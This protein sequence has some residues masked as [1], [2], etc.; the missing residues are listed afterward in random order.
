MTT[1]LGVSSNKRF[2]T[3]SES[4]F[5]DNIN[6]DEDINNENIQFLLVFL[7]LYTQLFS[8][9]FNLALFILYDLRIHF[10]TI[11]PAL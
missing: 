1:N 11:I 9:A 5:D 8:N 6:S 2:N 10:N 3:D 7:L 4:D